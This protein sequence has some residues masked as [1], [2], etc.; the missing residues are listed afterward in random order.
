MRRRVFN[1]TMLAL[2]GA[3]AS[4]GCVQGGVPPGPDFVELIRRASPAVVGVGDERG[5]VGTGFRL[6][7]T[8][9][10]VTAAHLLRPA[11]ANPDVFWE[12]KR[13]PA[14]V[15]RVDTNSDLA[16]LELPADAPMP[17]LPLVALA[18]A[19]ATGTWIVVLGRPFGTKTTATVGIV[20][21]TPGTIA[22]PR[23]MER[24]Q[25]NAAV[26]PGNSG[27][28]VVNLQG[29]VV[30]VA[31]ALLPA[32]QGLA[33]ATPAAAVTQLLSPSAGR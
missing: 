3:M 1:S 4:A 27:G 17:G 21:A 16:I 18:S 30:G 24:I 11:P 19:P 28:P 22:T 13:W 5:V 26:N 31:S 9:F 23:L 14:R 2:A 10:V 15:V 6:V 25:I 8:R 7:D 29:E 32:G 33:L 12:D 20:S